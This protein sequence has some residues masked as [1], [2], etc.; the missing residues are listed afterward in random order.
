V[1]C[2]TYLLVGGIWSG[3]SHTSPVGC[4]EFETIH[5]RKIQ[6]ART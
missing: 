1:Q 5:A 6:Y 3:S 2:L 4:P